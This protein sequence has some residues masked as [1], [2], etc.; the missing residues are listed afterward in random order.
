MFS[1][2][3][4][5]KAIA[6]PYSVAVIGVALTLSLFFIQI[7]NATGEATTSPTPSPTVTPVITPT[8]A[9][10]VVPY[11]LT[12]V[13]VQQDTSLTVPAPVVIEKTIIQKVEASRPV[14]FY[15]TDDRD[16][17]KAGQTVT[18]RLVVNNPFD[19]DLTEVKIVDHIPPYLIPNSAKPDATPNEAQSTV[20][21]DN[22]TISA[23]SEVT[24]ALLARVAPDAPNSFL[25]RNIA[26]LNGP[27]VRLTAYDTSTV[28]TSPVAVAPIQAPPIKPASVTARTG[29]PQNI[30]TLLALITA[31]GGVGLL[32]VYR[33][34]LKPRSFT[35]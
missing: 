8:P 27:G 18:Y 33:F 32:V 19:Y 2:S 6:M 26:D 20:T 7:A 10:T 34:F 23:K 9:P 22:V 11:N 29:T 31:V 24:F 28:V 35:F 15:K 3:A 17:V 13:S 30:V 1:H 25:L 21:W 12:Q 5:T 14:T 4:N 16:I